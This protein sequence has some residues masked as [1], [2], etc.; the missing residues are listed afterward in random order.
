MSR[1]KLL[2]LTGILLSVPALISYYTPSSQ[3]KSNTGNIS[4][5]ISGN[6]TVS[7]NFMPTDTS[8]KSASIQIYGYTSPLANVYLSGHGATSTTL[9]EITGRFV[10]DNT[11]IK[12]NI[13]EIC[14]YAK[15]TDGRTSQPTCV[16]IY[17]D[18]NLK[19]VG[20]I[21]LAPTFTVAKSEVAP[22]EKII[23][24]GQSIP[25]RF[26]RIN[27]SENSNIKGNNS[28]PNKTQIRLNTDNEGL[29]Y[30]TTQSDT[31]ETKEAYSSTQY[32]GQNSPKST[33][34]VV[35]VLPSW[36]V[37]LR[38]I[39][40]PMASYALELALICEAIIAFLYFIYFRKKTTHPL[41]IYQDKLISRINN[42]IA[43]V[44]KHALLK[45]S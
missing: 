14:L 30:F 1:Y 33:T 23:F 19:G 38:N 22:G 29:F 34:L 3:I 42:S 20:P 7:L 28:L 25:N 26:V 24:G 41:A 18:I 40:R 43:T 31:P 16:P 27:I 6:T 13:K 15:D 12:E 21:I 35:K 5:S 9:A 11:L 32:D 45:I 44:D 10:F 37:L 17:F 8:L 36:L 39:V 4:Q 2:L